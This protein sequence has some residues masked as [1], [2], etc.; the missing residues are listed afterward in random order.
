MFHIF[1]IKNL[2]ETKNITK[3]DFSMI[4]FTL[5]KTNIPLMKTFVDQF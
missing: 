5:F 3:D 2:L 4:L 1:P